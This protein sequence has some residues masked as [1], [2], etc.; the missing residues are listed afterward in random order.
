MMKEFM[1]SLTFQCKNNCG[2]KDMNIY[3]AMDHHN[4]C[5]MEL[6]DCPNGCG[7]IILNKDLPEHLKVCELAKF[8]CPTCKLYYYK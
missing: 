3:Q 1:Q 5:P 6:K 8:Q 4:K 7:H 2:C